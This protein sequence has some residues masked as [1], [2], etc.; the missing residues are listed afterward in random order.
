MNEN[1]S[2]ILIR[3]MTEMATLAEEHRDLLGVYSKLDMDF[4][5]ANYTKRKD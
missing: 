2:P 5:F 3:L 4:N 1:E